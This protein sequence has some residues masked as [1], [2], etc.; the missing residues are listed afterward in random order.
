MTGDIRRASIILGRH[1]EF[2][3]AFK[4]QL[5]GAPAAHPLTDPA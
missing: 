3:P 5:H 1:C 4:L 2:L